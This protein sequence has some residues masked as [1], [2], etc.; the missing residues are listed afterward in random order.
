MSQ[1]SIQ[2]ILVILVLLVPGMGLA[3]TPFALN[4]LGQRIDPDDARMV[5]RGSW[6]MAVSDTLNPGFKNLAGLSSL[7]M[8]ALKFTG[9]GDHVTS[10]DGTN[11]RG[12]NRTI[13]PDIR[14]ALP[15][16]KSK[17]AFSTGFEVNRSNQWKT[18]AE[19]EWSAWDDELTGNE[20]FLREGTLWSV[21]LGLA[22]EVLPGFSVGG[23]LG[24][25][26]GTIRESVVTEFI[27]PNN[28]QT[29]NPA[30]LYLTNGR[31]QEDEFSGTAVT[32]SMLYKFQDRVT[33]GFSWRGAH[34]LDVDR[35]VSVGGVGERFN[36]AWV[37]RFPDE[38]RAGFDLKLVDR[39]HLGADYQMMNYDGS[40]GRE[41]WQDHLNDEFTYNVGVERRQAFVRRGG[42]NNLPIRLG[43]QH[44]QWGYAVDGNPV[45]ETIYSV[46]TG[47]PFRQKLGQVDVALSYGKIGSLS[48]HQLESDVWR[49]TMSF[50]GLERWW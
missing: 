29:P 33:V 26:R 36:D 17:L 37:Y 44:R 28:G 7:N 18:F 12:T 32:W 16:I 40:H 14:V 45:T 42:W 48:D 31:V 1:R 6:G 4:S 2:T 39:W 8:V 24:L 41:D 49:F 10:T 27:T 19:G 47:F 13:S 9:Y 23:S 46:G 35:K 25:V 50:T 43:M 22:Y 15:I 38:Y 11:E 34:D 3:Q 30:P 21:P 5:G 20:Q